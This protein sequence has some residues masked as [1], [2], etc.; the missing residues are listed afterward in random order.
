MRLDHID[1]AYKAHLI[2]VIAECASRKLKEFEQDCED[3]MPV[4]Q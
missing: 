1:A 3:D 4:S 2:K